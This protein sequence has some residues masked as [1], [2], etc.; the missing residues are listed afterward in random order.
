MEKLGELYYL[1]Y[2]DARA[3]MPKIREYLGIGTSA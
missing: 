2:H 3:M 1:G